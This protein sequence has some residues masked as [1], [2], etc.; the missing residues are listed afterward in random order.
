MRILNFGSMNIDTVFSISHAA[1]PGESL[2][3]TDPQ[4]HAGGK[5]L[6]QSVA[7]ARAGADVCHAGRVGADG[8]FLLRLLAADGVDVS[9]VMTDPDARSGGAI[10]QVEPE[11]RNTMLIYGGANRRLDERQID[12][13]LSH[14]AS[15]DLL[16]MQN[17]TNLPQRILRQAAEKGLY[18]VYNPSP[19]TDAVFHLP[20]EQVNLLIVNEDEGAALAG[21]DYPPEEML[22]RLQALGPETVILTLGSAGSLALSGGKV[23]RQEIFPVEAVDST[24]AGDTYAGYIATSLARSLPLEQAMRLAAAASAISVTRHGAA[25]SIPKLEEVM[26]FLEERTAGSE[27]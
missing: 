26:A 23:I 22:R 24:G 19:I 1:A 15:G 2:A 8:D 27:N 5:G 20:Y 7:A 17:E 10:I 3:V 4:I 9:F 12:E 13:V 21:G 14:F 25:A 16:M 6:N 18:T 11:G